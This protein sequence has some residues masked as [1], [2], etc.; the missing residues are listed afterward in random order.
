MFEYTPKKTLNGPRKIYPF[1][2]AHPE[3]FI[4]LR[5]L[6]DTEIARLQDKS[7]YN[8]LA[9]EQSMVRFF[10][11]LEEM[12][13]SMVVSWGGIIINGKELE[14]SEE[15]RGVLSE[16]LD[17]VTVESTDEDGE[18]ATKTLWSYVTEEMK[19]AEEAER[20]N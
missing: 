7:K 10:K 1:P 11:F 12:K 6:S 17:N 15:G 18:P 9:K 13:K 14:A 3:M 19:K 16:M 20:K 5:R 2:E 8:P 4:E